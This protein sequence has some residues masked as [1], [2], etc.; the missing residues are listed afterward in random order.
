MAMNCGL[1][2]AEGRR[3]LTL[4][5][6]TF[7]AVIASMMRAYAFALA[8]IMPSMLLLLGSLRRGAGQHRAQFRYRFSP[9]WV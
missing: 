4:L 3:C 9:C 1:P 8:V 2:P 7:D 6:E 5:T